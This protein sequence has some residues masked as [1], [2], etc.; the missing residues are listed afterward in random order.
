MPTGVVCAAA[1]MDVSEMTS[2]IPRAI[3]RIMRIDLRGKDGRA[4]TRNSLARATECQRVDGRRGRGRGML[5][6]ALTITMGRAASDAR[7]CGELVSCHPGD[8]P[9]GGRFPMGRGGLICFDHVRHRSPGTD[10]HFRDCAP[11]LWT[12]EPAPA[13]PIA[14]PRH[15]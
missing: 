5:S 15:A 12:E 9:R 4:A 7:H 14:R 6:L 10:P 13:R 11:R 1:G 2:T 8:D 3:L